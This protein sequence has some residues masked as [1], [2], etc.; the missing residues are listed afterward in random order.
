MTKDEITAA[1]DAEVRTFTKALKSQF[2]GGLEYAKVA[3]RVG[4]ALIADAR[5]T[6][7]GMKKAV[8][9]AKKTAKKDAK[10]AKKAV[11]AAKKTAKKS[12]KK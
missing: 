11:E 9:A 6:R 10:A 12:A 1:V 7:K 5:D 2:S 3:R 8:E 4:R